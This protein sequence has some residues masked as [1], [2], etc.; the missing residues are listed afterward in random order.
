MSKILFTDLDGTLF[1]DSKEL[2]PGNR[3]AIRELLD[4]GHHIVLCSGRA[5]VSVHRLAEELGLTT[6]GCYIAAYNGALIYD[7]SSE[8]CIFRRGIP[9]P[10][11][12]D[13][14]TYADDLL[15]QVHTYTE[16]KVLTCRKTE[17]LLSYCNTVHMDWIQADETL[18]ALNGR[19]P[20]KILAI[21]DNSPAL[22]QLNEYIHS[23][24]RGQLDSYRS[25]PKLLEIVPTG[26]SKGNAVRFLCDY[27]NIPLENSVAA[28]DAPN[29]ISMLEAA[30]IGAVMKNA[31]PGMEQYGQ[32]ITQADNNHDGLAEIIHR[33]I[34]Q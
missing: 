9:I 33:F 7:M 1:T 24:Y 19:E 11:I 6:P 2:T 8:T 31:M 21:T 20:E 34:L 28:G 29:D 14:F 25:T 30:H 10:I 5:L 27:L 17:E 16:T 23:T 32:Y 4:Q 18:S 3:S 13:I 26:C 15:I 22:D 12:Q